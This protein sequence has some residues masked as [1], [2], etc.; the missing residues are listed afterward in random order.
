MEAK[1][2]PDR[3]I[4]SESSDLFIVE[5][6][7]VGLTLLQPVVCPYYIPFLLYAYL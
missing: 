2:S 4:G 7:F 6:N 1:K 3:S 5:V